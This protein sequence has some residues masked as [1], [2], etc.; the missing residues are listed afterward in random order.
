[1]MQWGNA[2][3]EAEAKLSMESSLVDNPLPTSKTHSDYFLQLWNSDVGKSF[4]MIKGKE[5]MSQSTVSETSSSKLESCSNN[6]SSALAHKSQEEQG[7]EY[8][9]KLEDGIAGSESEYYEFLDSYDSAL[10]RLLDEEIGFSA[11]SESFLDTLF[12]I[13]D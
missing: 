6:G 10:N 9:P 1:M 5:I 7:S 4:R 8:R 2:G 3:I 13:S 12:G 11:Q